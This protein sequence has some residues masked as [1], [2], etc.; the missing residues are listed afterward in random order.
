MSEKVKETTL[1]TSRNER[2]DAYIVEVGLPKRFS[3]DIGETL[4]ST[5]E[6]MNKE[7]GENHL[8]L[9]LT[10]D[11]TF[12]M[13]DSLDLDP[14][15]PELPIILV[16]DR[17]P[18]EVKSGDEEVMIKLGALERDQDVRIVLEGIQT[19]LEE[20][21]FMTDSTSS[22]R[23]DKLNEEFEDI[24]GIVVTLTSKALM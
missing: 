14:F 13:L 20:D 3:D 2:Y 21:G 7:L 19:L 18:S 17:H 16:L 11:E 4:V 5:S 12:S 22:Q 1:E 6:K 9:K 24:E 23:K 10:E 15:K 8:Y